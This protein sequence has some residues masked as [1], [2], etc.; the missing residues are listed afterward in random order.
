VVVAT[1]EWGKSCRWC[2]ASTP[3]SFR[4]PRWSTNWTGSGL[5]A[6]ALAVV[7]YCA[8]G[9]RA[10]QMLQMVQY[11]RVIEQAKGW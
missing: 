4:T 9:C 5:L 8:G 6:S 3:R 7:E 11:R 2:S 10:E 1:G